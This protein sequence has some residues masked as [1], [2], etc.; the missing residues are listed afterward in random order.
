MRKLIAFIPFLLLSL[1]ACGPRMIKNTEVPDTEE[2]RAIVDVVERYRIAVE[3]R[4][5]DSMKEIVSRRYY[6][7]AGTTSDASDDYGYEQLETKVLPVLRDSIKSVQFNIFLKRVDVT[8]D[9]A[10]ADYEYYYK[11]W[12]VDGGKDRWLA[13]NDFA[14]MELS[15]EDGVWRIVGGL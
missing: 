11:F 6:S 4:D 2:N 13:K 1:A 3:K 10:F 8:G 15:N 14:R 7:N 12:Y 9:R 5:L